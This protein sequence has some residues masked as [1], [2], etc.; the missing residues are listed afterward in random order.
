M[1]GVAGAAWWVARRRRRARGR[2]PLDG[3]VVAITGGSR[4]LGL[5]LA[6]EFA[7]LG[8]HVAICARDR[9]E[10]ERARERLEAL[11]GEVLVHACDVGDR[12][13]ARGF[14]EVVDARFGRTDILV[15]NA[16]IISTGP[17]GSHAD[18]DFGTS[19]DVMFW[20]VYEPSMAVIEGMRRR[21]YGRIVNITSLGGKIAVP[22]LL[23]YASA[24][25]AAVGFSEGL[26]AELAGSGV[27]VTTVVPGLMRTGSYLNA[28][29]AGRPRWEFAWF[30]VLGN[31][32]LTSTDAGSAARRI[33]R[34]ARR[35][36]RR[37]HD[38]AAGAD[39][40]APAGGG[41]GGDG[42]PPRDREPLPP[43]RPG[44]P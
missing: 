6:E 40:R 15:N 10:L 34:A 31:L 33:V 23:P 38:R 41:A 21:E 43:A 20:G 16:G 26:R 42:E 7:R 32:P 9:G 8:C 14:L 44:S 5:V 35:R 37:G 24:K 28:E 30:S 1:L 18:T 19:L 4:G 36:R 2:E 3:R 25:F 22:H 39:R 17:L 12:A 27:Y 13:E 29:F 11:G